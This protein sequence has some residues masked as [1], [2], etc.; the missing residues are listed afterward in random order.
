MESAHQLSNP[1]NSPEKIPFFL[2]IL[3]IKDTAWALAHHWT[4]GLEFLLSRPR[5]TCQQEGW[6]GQSWDQLHWNHMKKTSEVQ[7]ETKTINICY[8]QSFEE[9]KAGIVG[10]WCLPERHRWLDFCALLLSFCPLWGVSSCDARH[11]F[12]WSVQQALHSERADPESQMF[13]IFSLLIS[14]CCRMSK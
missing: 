4:K 2:K 1:L 8:T 5:V 3:E 10:F 6:G 13:S 12:R 7:R 11:A 9:G 14:T